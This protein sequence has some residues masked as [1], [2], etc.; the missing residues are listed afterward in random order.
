MK[1]SILW[2]AICMLSL[3]VAGQNTGIGTSTPHPSAVLDITGNKGL[4]LPRMTT[5]VRNGISGPAK[6]LLVYD[7][8]AG[9]FVFYNGTFW[10]E[11][12]HTGNNLW[13]KNGGNM[14]SNSG[15]VGI[16][17]I[18]PGFALHVVNSNAQDGGWAQGIVVENTNEG[19]SIGEAAISFKNKSFSPNKQWSVGIN[20]T[21]S[22]LAFNFGSTFAGVNTRMVIDTMGRVALGTIEPEPSAQLHMNSTARGLILPRMSSAQRKAIADPALGLFVYDT[23]KHSLY[24]F[25]GMTWVA[26]AQQAPDFV[27]VSL[28][29]VDTIPQNF[30]DIGT[31]VAIDGELAVT[32]STQYEINGLA[33]VGCVFVFK[34]NGG[35]WDYVQQII[36]NTIKQGANFGASLALSGNL[37]VV[38]SPYWDA[39]LVDKGKIWYYQW[40]GT[41]FQFLDSLVISPGTTGAY[42]GF[43]VALKGNTLVVGASQEDINGNE[44]GGIYVYT[45]NPATLRF[46]NR[47][48]LSAPNAKPGDKLGYSVDVDGAYIVAGAPFHPFGAGLNK[49]I[50]HVWTGSV[51]SWGYQDSCTFASASTSYERLGLYLTLNGSN[52]VCGANYKLSADYNPGSAIYFKRNGS[53]WDKIQEIRS[54]DTDNLS[55]VPQV[56]A[57]GNWLLIGNSA[58]DHLSP[59]RGNVWVYALESGLWVKKRRIYNYTTNDPGQRWPDALGFDGNSIMI[60]SY[61]YNDR[62]G[63][64]FFTTVIN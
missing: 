4:L 47:V 29:T 27:P 60:G 61:T 34:K 12:V 49:G 36:P 17:T 7:S 38:G 19:E 31:E 53:Q 55:S 2:L 15:N 26:F 20:Q 10:T 64:V 35:R 18:N 48:R 37:L 58:E 33:D 59:P 46:A 28:R 54:E 56:V 51:A 9:S 5:P 13:L 21:S 3:S 43:S 52:I 40:D 22:P 45:F 32:K 41:S 44:A 14:Y 25:D 8:T 39:N 23:D 42:F 63:A 62:Q 11:M 24:M 16:G 6:G 57:K 30:L 1:N 50:A